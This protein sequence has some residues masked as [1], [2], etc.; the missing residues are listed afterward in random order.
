VT[1]RSPAIGR[2]ER[3]IAAGDARAAN[4]FW[5]EAA[6]RTTPLVDPIAGDAEHVSLSF[7]FRGEAE[8]KAVAGI[9]WVMGGAGLQP[10]TPIA[11]TDVWYRSTVVRRGVRTA[12]RFLP[13]PPAPDVY[14]ISPEAWSALD[15]DGRIT[16]DP[17]NPRT[18]QGGSLA[19]LES[20]IELPGADAQPWIDERD[21][22][23]KGKLAPHRFE[24]AVLGGARIVW[25]Y[26]P[27]GYRTEGDR[28]AVL[29]LHDGYAYANIGLERILDN[30]IAARKIPPLVCVLYQWADRNTELMCNESV[31]KAIADELLGAWLPPRLH[32]TDDPARIIIGGGER[33]RAL[34]RVLRDSPA[35]RFQ[36]RDLAVRSVLVGAGGT[37]AGRHDAAGRRV[38]VADGAGQ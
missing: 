15:K 16:T 14:G 30:L 31:T 38:G 22:V 5:A 10:L 33:R 17:L 7:V 12:Y 35:R 3:R 2:L 32:V 13:D 8:T 11:G 19:P 36:Q 9:G 4:E 23:P 28:Y 25:T 37:D 27:P 20:I 26:E 34:R 6:S 29:V 1:T 21:G 18:F 24:S